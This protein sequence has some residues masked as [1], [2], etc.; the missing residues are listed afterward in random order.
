MSLSL[1]ELYCRGLIPQ[2]I[3]N[4]TLEAKALEAKDSD[5]LASTSEPTSTHRKGFFS[6]LIGCISAVYNK[7]TIY[8]QKAPKTEAKMRE[9]ETA[10]DFAPEINQ[11]RYEDLS[12]KEKL[13]LALT[14]MFFP[15]QL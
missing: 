4:Q 3:N 1:S 2:A 7:I 11:R 15:R 5:P 12:D 6:F 8:M 10:V 14:Q 9:E 13:E